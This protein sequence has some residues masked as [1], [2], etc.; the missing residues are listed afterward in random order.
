MLNIPF[1]GIGST[2]RAETIKKIQSIPAQPSTGAPQATGG[3]SPMSFIT[4]GKSATPAQIAA[5]NKLI[6]KA[7]S[8]VL[9]LT[10]KGAAVA[11]AGTAGYGLIAAAAPL[12]AGSSISGSTAAAVTSKTIIKGGLP[13]AVGA[14]VLG[15]LLGGG[16]KQEQKQTA[17]QPTSVNPDQITPQDQKGAIDTTLTGKTD[18]NADISQKTAAQ[19][20]SSNEYGGSVFDISDINDFW[21]APTTTTSTT[22]QAIP[23]VDF[24]SGL[25]NQTPQ[26][27]TQE[28]APIQ[29]TV[30]TPSQ[31]QE[32]QATQ[33][34]DMGL[35]ALLAIGAIV[36]LG[37]KNA[38]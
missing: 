14:G 37:G 2:Q 5:A 20:T 1:Q 34:T 21:Y 26:T 6:G 19:T 31:T 29:L 17:S 25:L 38:R 32:Q 36:L 24:F 7:A 12:V 35:I 4:S 28:A 33:S 27:L 15:F 13:L 16:S 3:V 10:A 23:S 9:Q 30:T 11:A 8:N 18:T 22:T